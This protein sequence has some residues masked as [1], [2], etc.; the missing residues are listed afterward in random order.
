[1][2]NQILRLSASLLYW[3]WILTCD[4]LAPHPAWVRFFSRINP[5]FRNR[6]EKSRSTGADLKYSAHKWVTENFPS[7]PEV[8]ASI[9]AST[10]LANP[11][12]NHSG[13]RHW[14]FP[15]TLGVSLAAAAAFAVALIV[16]DPSQS[17]SAQTPTAANQATPGTMADAGNS[18][19]R[20]GAN[21]GLALPARAVVP[22]SVF[23]LPA[24]GIG[25]VSLALTSSYQSELEQTFSNTGQ[26]II[27]MPGR[28]IPAELRNSTKR[29]FL[30]H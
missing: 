3:I 26:T 4:D 11:A 22:A 30:S 6:I 21:R 10:P 8:D 15:V 14:S 18:N 27:E 13:S 16:S 1:M 17:D 23:G 12:A 25:D 19:T 20:P 2:K 7:P 9:I 24:R 5:Q 29:L 28:L